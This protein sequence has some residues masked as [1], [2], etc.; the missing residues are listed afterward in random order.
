MYTTEEYKRRIKELAPVA[1]EIVERKTPEEA[2]EMVS[3]MNPEDAYI[4]GMW[5]GKMLQFDDFTRA[6]SGV[7]VKIQKSEVPNDFDL[8]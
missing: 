2:R 7:V 8:N 4:V 6:I 1:K 3:K 5:L